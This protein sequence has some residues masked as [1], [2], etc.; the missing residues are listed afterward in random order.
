VLITVFFAL[1]AWAWTDTF[2]PFSTDLTTV[3]G[4]W[5]APFR[6]LYA[7]EDLSFGL[8]VSF[9]F[10]GRPILNRLNRRPGLTTATHL[11][12]VWLL[13][14]W[15]PQDNSYRTTNPTD[16]GTEAALVYGFNITLM[17]AAGLVVV[18]LSSSRRTPEQ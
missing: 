4:T 2:W 11:A 13:A 17:I 10:L 15:W 8:G 7:F 12:V 5:H 14:S 16:W 9:L 3:P 18:F 1:M 6:L